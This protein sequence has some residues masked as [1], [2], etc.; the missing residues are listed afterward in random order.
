MISSNKGMKTK[1]STKLTMKK[2]SKN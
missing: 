1:S 2:L